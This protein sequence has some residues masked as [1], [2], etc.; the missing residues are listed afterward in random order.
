MPANSRWDLIRGSSN[1][2]VDLHNGVTN[3][4]VTGCKTKGAWIDS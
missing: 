2:I 3:L 4:K 1:Q